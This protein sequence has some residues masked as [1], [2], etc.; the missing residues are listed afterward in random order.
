MKFSEYIK[1]S[2]GEYCHFFK[3]KDRKWYFELGDENRPRAYGP[4]MSEHEAEKYLSDNH[5]NPGGWSSD[6]SGTQPAPR[7]PYKET[8]YV[9]KA[10]GRR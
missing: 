3:A 2:T 8:P 6:D 10:L 9:V 5:A 4:F 1:E 7:N